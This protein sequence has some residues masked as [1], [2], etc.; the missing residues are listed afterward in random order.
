MV[1]HMGSDPISAVPGWD[2]E[3]LMADV[4]PGDDEE[5]VLGDV[6]GVIA[7]ALEMTP[8]PCRRS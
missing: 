7:D 1:F 4:F 3:H 6:G 5:H 8:D 2:P